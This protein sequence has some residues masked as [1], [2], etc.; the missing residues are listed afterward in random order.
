MG[1]ERF[2]DPG[3]TTVFSHGEKGGADAANM[4]DADATFVSVS[5][6]SPE[7]TA[8]LGARKKGAK[9]S[10]GATQV[11]SPGGGETQVLRQG[12]GETQVLRPGA[13]GAQAPGAGQTQVLG[14]D[15]TQVLG[16]DKTQA[17]APAP[18]AA[19]SPHGY[20]PEQAVNP[21]M[22]PDAAFEPRGAAYSSPSATSVMPAELIAEH[23]RRNQ[24][25][26]R[27]GARFAA[28]SFAQEAPPQA[29]QWDQA[30]YAPRPEY[31]QPVYA[32]PAPKKK[33]HGCLVAFI[34]V[35]VVLVILGAAA[36]F[37][38]DYAVQQT[39]VPKEE[40]LSRIAKPIQ[41]FISG[42]GSR[43]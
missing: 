19:F 43:K 2:N 38:L 4:A 9:P 8:M 39:G 10:P 23:R 42:L 31:A 40:I 15:A 29:Q 14:A 41:D 21:Q 33:G 28:G 16:A 30:A 22:M 17:F 34:T 20:I 24:K 7:E 25:D 11:I 26:A 6:L 18:D 13:G 36:I 37:A 32:Q 27:A 3:K 12:G 5:S 35:L 1:D